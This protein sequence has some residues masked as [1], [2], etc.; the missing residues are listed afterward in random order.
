MEGCHS[1]PVRNSFLNSEVSNMSPSRAAILSENDL[2]CI[3]ALLAIC[4]RDSVSS[5]EYRTADICGIVEV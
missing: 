5:L 3:V 4:S 2:D 1:L